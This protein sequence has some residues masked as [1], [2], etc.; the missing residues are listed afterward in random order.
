MPAAYLS[1]SRDPQA[2]GK[3]AAAASGPTESV[4][5]DS[6]LHEQAMQDAARPEVASADGPQSA[7]AANGQQEQNNGR[8]AAQMLTNGSPAEEWLLFNDF[9]ISPA[10]ADDVRRLY[11]AQKVPVVLYYRQ[12]W[13]KPS[14]PQRH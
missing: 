7:P 6:D 13:P 11:G 10:E 9:A 1:T 14:P 2:G 4:A 8:G 3:S 5:T 12:V